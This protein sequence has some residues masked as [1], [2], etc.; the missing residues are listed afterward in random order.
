SGQRTDRSMQMQIVETYVEKKSDALP[1]LF[2]DFSRNDTL[3]FVKSIFETDE[4]STQF[5][6][7]HHRKL[8]DILSV[9]FEV[10]GFLLQ[11]HAIA[12]RTGPDN[13]KVFHPLSH[14]FGSFVALLFEEIDDPLELRVPIGT[15]ILDGRDFHWL[16]VAIHKDVQNV[17]GN[18]LQR[19]TQREFMTLQDCF[20]LLEYPNVTVLPER[21]Y[22]TAA[23]AE[24]FVR[25]D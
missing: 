23:N 16:F 11:A 17:L 1:N 21:K 19:C 18:I 15:G 8:G 9:E 10:Q 24:G 6:D 12:F 5:I 4:P 20:D 13:R 2:Q 22:P 7:S 14:R 25:H 3:S